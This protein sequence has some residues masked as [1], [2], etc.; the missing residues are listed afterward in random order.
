MWYRVNRLSVSSERREK[1]KER[2]REIGKKV[3]GRGK[4]V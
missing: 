3:V 1:E 2:E 4:F